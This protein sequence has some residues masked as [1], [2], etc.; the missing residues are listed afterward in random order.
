MYVY[1]VFYDTD[2]LSLERKRELLWDAKRLSYQ[3][4]IDELNEG[5]AARRKVKWVR[6]ETILKEVNHVYFVFIL[7]G[8]TVSNLPKRSKW[9]KTQFCIEVGFR[10]TV[11]KVDRFLFINVDTKHLEFFRE[12]YELNT[13][14]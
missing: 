12:K 14:L 9:F 3:W 8:G 1:D 6:F 5:S 7:R 11:G 4:H 2:H 13:K 10:C